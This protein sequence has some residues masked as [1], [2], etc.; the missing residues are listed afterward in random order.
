M[1]YLSARCF[2]WLARIV[3]PSLRA[4]SAD[5][6]GRAKLTRWTRYVT[7]GVALVQSYGFARFVESI[8]GAVAH[9]GPAFI[10]QTMIVL[11]GGAIVAMLIGERLGVPPHD[12][13]ENEP[14][15]TTQSS[16]VQLTSGESDPPVLAAVPDA[17]QLGPGEYR[18]AT[19]DRRQ[20][21][22]AQARRN[23]G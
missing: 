19:L 11:T 12:T 18:G 21:A 4:M 7:M 17:M 13:E 16:G 6:S 15:I 2:L 10:G 23:S 3:N 22:E 14:G 1:P 8:P 5:E 20:R 9:P